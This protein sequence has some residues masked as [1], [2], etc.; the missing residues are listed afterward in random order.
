[1]KINKVY[2]L[3]A[4]GSGKTFLAKKLCRILNIEYFDL[5]D[6][7]WEKKYSVKRDEDE[8]DRLLQKIV[9]KKQWIVEGVYTSWTG[10]VVKDSDLVIWLDSPTH[11]LMWR[12]FSRYLKKKDKESLNSTLTL[13]NYVRNYRKKGQDSG[14]FK[15]RKLIEKHD[16]NFVYIKNKEEVNN[17]LKNFLKKLDR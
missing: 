1:M 13:L 3:G 9:K 5:D 6:I 14:Y 4:P 2:V 11:V 17:F 10:E 16:V 8:R 12:I 7:F 15:H